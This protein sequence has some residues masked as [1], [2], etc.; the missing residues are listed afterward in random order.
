MLCGLRIQETLFVMNGSSTIEDLAWTVDIRAMKGYDYRPCTGYYANYSYWL[1][2]A[3]QLRNR[4]RW[5]ASV[6]NPNECNSYKQILALCN[7]RN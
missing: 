4:E 2:F 6:L 7:R 1:D 5:H 3:L